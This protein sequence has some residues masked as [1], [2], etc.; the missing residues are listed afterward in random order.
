MITFISKKVELGVISESDFGPF[1]KVKFRRSKIRINPQ[2]ISGILKLS[3]GHPCYTQQ[4]CHEVWSLAVKRG[5]VIEED[6]DTA[7]DAILRNEESFYSSVLENLTAIQLRVLL[8]IALGV[9]QLY[10]SD[11]LA[12]VGLSSATVQKA[13]KA[14]LNKNLVTKSRGE[15][16]IEDPFFREFIVRKVR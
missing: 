8:M 5:E 4:L 1:I 10:S 3:R 9:S 2:L 12:R 6:L 14:L 16:H 13:A 11:T 15:L 7:V